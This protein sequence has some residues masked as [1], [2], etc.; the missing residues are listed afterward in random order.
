[1]LDVWS[2]LNNSIESI[3]TLVVCTVSVI[4]F[5]NQPCK[6]L[7][8][9]CFFQQVHC[10]DVTM[11]LNSPTRSVLVNEHIQMHLQV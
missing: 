2:H 6:P 1:M 5:C 11:S 9:L 7:Q 8:A 3:K 10:Q 4:L